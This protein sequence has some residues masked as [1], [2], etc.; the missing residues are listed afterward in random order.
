MPEATHPYSVARLTA[1]S[2]WSNY[3]ISVTFQRLLDW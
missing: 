3:V 1:F 2:V